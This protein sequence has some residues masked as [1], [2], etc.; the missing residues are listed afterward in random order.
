MAGQ[1]LKAHL[2]IHL[3]KVGEK[4]E[5]SQLHNRSAFESHQLLYKVLTCRAADAN[6]ELLRIQ[7]ASKTEQ[8][9]LGS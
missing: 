7:T 3:P 6:F 1:I 2:Q 5:T 9:R 8:K 4:R